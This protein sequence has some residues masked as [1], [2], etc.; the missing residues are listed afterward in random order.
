MTE[1]NFYLQKLPNMAIEKLRL[2]GLT[3]FNRPHNA[4]A[5]FI[6]AASCYEIERR[7][8]NSESTEPPIEAEPPV[9]DFENWSDGDVGDA[10]FVLTAASYAE[11]HDEK[12][13]AGEFIDEL[14]VAVTCVARE[15]FFNPRGVG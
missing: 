2:F 14:V 8:W 10:L 11:F 4:L 5:H 12:K 3:Q 9:I 1:L 7:H 15:S 13:E 6:D